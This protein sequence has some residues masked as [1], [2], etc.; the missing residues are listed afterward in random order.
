ML[1]RSLL[2]LGLVGCMSAFASAQVSVEYWRLGDTPNGFNEPILVTPISGDVTLTLVV[3]LSGGDGSLLLSSGDFD[4][5]WPKHSG[6]EES[7]SDRPIA[8]VKVIGGVGQGA[9][10]KDDLA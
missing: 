2:V 6:L 8:A 10:E 1:K 4:F 5:S 9:I 7:V 3:G